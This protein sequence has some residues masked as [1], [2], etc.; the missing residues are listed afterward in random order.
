MWHTV[1]PL[2]ELGRRWSPYSYGF[3]NPMRFVDSD[4][5]WPIL[6]G[7]SLNNGMRKFLMAIAPYSDLNDVVFLGSSLLSP[8][9]GKDPKNIDGTTASPEDVEAAK[10]GLLLPAMSG[11]GAKKTIDA[12]GDIIEDVSAATRINK[13]ANKAES[14]FMLYEV[15]D[16]D[17]SVLKV[18]KADAD[19]TNSLGQPVRMKASERQ[20]QKTHPGATAEKVQD[21]GTTTTGQAKEAEAARVKEH[22]ANGNNLPLDK[23]RDKRYNNQ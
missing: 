1:D 16:K 10:M 2:A 9:T 7:P 14:N 18:G 6:G 11:S 5:M 3:D 4:G 12:A 8:I 22:R 13:N 20:A 21:L 17:G 15:K 19:R 23:E